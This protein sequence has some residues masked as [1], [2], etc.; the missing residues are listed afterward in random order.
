MIRE[1]ASQ[2][3]RDK[4][5]HLLSIETQEEN[6]FVIN[7]VK[8]ND[9]L[10]LNQF[11]TLGY[12]ANLDPNNWGWQR[13]NLNVSKPLTYKNWC[14]GEPDNGFEN[15]H[16]M[17]VI[18]RCWHDVP[19]HFDWASVCER[20]ANIFDPN[21]DE[22]FFFTFPGEHKAVVP[23]RPATNFDLFRVNVSKEVKKPTSVYH[24]VKVEKKLI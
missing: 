15:E 16:F 18:N 13:P 20:E 24:Q 9:D 7:L 6:E 4:H 10:I 19:G 11:W 3:C 14:R 2:H 5:M 1:D 17:A 8:K 12:N 21:L 22:T 23:C